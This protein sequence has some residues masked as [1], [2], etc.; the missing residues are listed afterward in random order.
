M[1]TR[2]GR[3]TLSNTLLMKN[4]SLIILFPPRTCLLLL[5]LLFFFFL[6]LRS[7]KSGGGGGSG[8]NG[9]GAAGPPYNPAGSYP[10]GSG[11]PPTAGVQPVTLPRWTIAPRNY[12]CLS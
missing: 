5:F 3:A 1:K 7:Q 4:V 8:A 6:F 9:I 10:P 11:P 2:L 12:S